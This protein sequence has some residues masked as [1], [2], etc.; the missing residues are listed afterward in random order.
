VVQG[1]IRTRKRSATLPD[2]SS[3]SLVETVSS[4]IIR[5][6][7]EDQWRRHNGESSSPRS[8]LIIDLAKN[9]QSRKRRK[10][11]SRGHK[12]RSKREVKSRENSRREKLSALGGGGGVAGE[13]EEFSRMLISADELKAR[14][15]KMEEARLAGQGKRMSFSMVKALEVPQVRTI[16]L[17]ASRCIVSSARVS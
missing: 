14:V 12:E 13:D 5:D 8:Q 10:K 3:Q 1:P 7:E 17:S 15:I 9:K 6:G 11:R 2:I 16:H 4:V